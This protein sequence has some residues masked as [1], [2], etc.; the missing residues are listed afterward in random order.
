MQEFHQ[1]CGLSHLGVRDSLR[2]WESLRKGQVDRRLGRTALVSNG[3]SLFTHRIQAT[4]ANNC[5]L[6]AISDQPRASLYCLFAGTYTV[7]RVLRTVPV[8]DKAKLVTFCGHVGLAE[9][10]SAR[11]NTL[12][13]AGANGPLN[14]TG[15]ARSQSA[16]VWAW[17][18][19]TPS[20][21]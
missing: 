19:G 16:G 13:V 3:K 2:N 15:D 12:T 4:P 17:L 8:A 1:L 14:R 10:H 9:R 6:T 18:P 21:R 11:P 5:I 20:G 7:I